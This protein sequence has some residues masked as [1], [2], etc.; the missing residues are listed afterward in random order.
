MDDVDSL[1][2]SLADLHHDETSFQ[3]YSD[4]T[5]SESDFPNLLSGP[6][7]KDVNSVRNTHDVD[8]QG[9]E[10]ARL[11][12]D[13]SEYRLDRLEKYRNYRNLDDYDP[14][15]LK[16]N[17]TCAR[18]VTFYQWT[19]T[20]IRDRPAYNHFQ[21]R[22][23]IHAPTKNDIYFINP[24][25]TLLRYCPMSRKTRTVLNLRQQDLA[26]VR[27]STMAVTPTLAL[28]GG[29]SGE[30]IA[31]NLVNQSI[32]TGH[33]TSDYANGI[34]NHM[35]IVENHAIVGS[36]DGGTRIMDL[37]TFKITQ[38]MTMPWPVNCAVMGDQGMICIVGDDKNAVLKDPKSGD[39]IAT[40]T[41]H[42]DYSFSAAFQPNGHLLATG[43][44][45]ETARVYD[46]RKCTGQENPCLAV[47]PATL[48]SVRSLTWHP[49]SPFQ[50]LTKTR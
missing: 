1:T 8:C 12:M 35:Q 22:R 39:T 5:D 30:F 31:C 42:S 41:G 46:V 17:A 4:D 3:N 20:R 14:K 36:N 6:M 34:T 23:L 25:G 37:T 24:Q 21:L 26:T 40:L 38:T 27:V 45:D 18:D 48:G 43:N 16:L 15:E 7:R 11:R 47:L 29:F 33:V 9:I 32:K 44:Q 49:V 50:Q 13:R 19:Q 28:L 10:W 2:D